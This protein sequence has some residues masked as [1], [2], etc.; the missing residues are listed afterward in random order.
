MSSVLK[1][2]D[3]FTVQVTMAHNSATDD[4]LFTT[5]DRSA[6]DPEKNTKVRVSVLH[7]GLL[8]LQYRFNYRNANNASGG[9]TE[10]ALK[11]W[12]ASTTKP[13]YSTDLLDFDG[14][15]AALLANALNILAVSAPERM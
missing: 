8:R 14:Q 11:G 7:A 6:I 5:A 2:L 1:D 3:S 12:D 13:L 10:S 15:N 9:I 4:D